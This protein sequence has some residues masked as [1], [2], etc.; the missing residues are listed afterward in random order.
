MGTEAQK[1]RYIGMLADPK[2]LRIGRWV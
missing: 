2:T 1:Q